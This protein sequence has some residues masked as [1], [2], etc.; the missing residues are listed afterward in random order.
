MA[1]PDRAPWR[2]V[3]ERFRSWSTIYRS[4]NRRSE[5]GVWARALERSQ[6][7]AQQSGDLSWVAPVDYMVVRVYQHGTIPP[8]EIGGS[9]E[10]QEVR[11]KVGGSCHRP[12]SPRVDDR[13]PP[14]L[15]RESDV[16]SPSSSRLGSQR[17]PAC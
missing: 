1:V 4:F 2:D 17:T 8:R 11:G 13:E 10:L 7:L 15:R 12:F 6:S 14:R 5:Q 9:V 16:L 3:P